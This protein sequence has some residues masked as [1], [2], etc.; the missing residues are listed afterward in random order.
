MKVVWSKYE[1]F[2]YEGA[3]DKCEIYIDTSHTLLSIHSFIFPTFLLLEYKIKAPPCGKVIKL[4]EEKSRVM[5]FIENYNKN[6]DGFDYLYFN[7][8]VATHAIATPYIRTDRIS[9]ILKEYFE[10]VKKLL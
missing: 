3:F 1:N 5:D 9:D 4:S 10:D 6:I 2:V 8:K 7:I